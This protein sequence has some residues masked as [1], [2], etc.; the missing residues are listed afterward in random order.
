MSALDADV[1]ARVKKVKELESVTN[2]QSGPEPYPLAA[3]VGQ[4]AIKAAMLM[5]GT[6]PRIRGVVIQGSRGTAK[7]VMARAVHKL[8]PPIERIKGS[9]YNLNPAEPKNIDSITRAELLAT[10]KRLEDFETEIVPCPF[11]QMPLDVQEDRMLGSVD[12]ELS[13]EKG[14]P[15][16]D[17]GLLASA[18]RG[19][20]YVDDIN[21]LDEGITNNLLEALSLGYVRVEREGVSVDYPF[22]PI[23]VATFNPEEATL[24]VQE[25]NSGFS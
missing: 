17:P 20:L 7:S 25:V 21:L 15:V 6:N 23:L 24:R 16:F 18:H 22:D 1:E 12:I 5:V 14:M 3:V 13:L 2:I 4:E 9:R 19:V 10:G 11:V 8:L